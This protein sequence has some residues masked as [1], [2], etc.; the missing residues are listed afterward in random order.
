MTPEQIERRQ[1]EN[2]ELRRQL[3]DVEELR[4]LTKNSNGTVF[5]ASLY[6]GTVSEA[7]DAQRLINR[8]INGATP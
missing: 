7:L 6:F 3:K 1:A 5:K 2:D 8:I 4:R